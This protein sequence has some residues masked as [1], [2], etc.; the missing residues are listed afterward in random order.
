MITEQPQKIIVL[1]ADGLNNLHKA[2]VYFI[3]GSSRILSYIYRYIHT[4]IN[5][6][7]KFIL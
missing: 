6:Y 2:H 3:H 5:I 7:G 1:I 4:Y